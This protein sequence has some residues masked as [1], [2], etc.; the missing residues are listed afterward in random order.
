MLRRRRARGKLSLLICVLAAAVWSA[1]AQEVSFTPRHDGISSERKRPRRTPT[2]EINVARAPQLYSL[3][4]FNLLFQEMCRLLEAEGRRERI[5]LVAKD[6]AGDEHE[7]PSCRALARQI[8][9]SCAPKARAQKGVTPDVTS[10]MDGGGSSRQ[11]Q[12]E[13]ADDGGNERKRYPRT[14]LIDVLSRISGG[15]YEFSPGAGAVFDAL[16]SYELR[17]LASP[18]LTVGERD[19]YG[20]VLTYLFSAWDGRPGSPLGSATPSPEEVADLVQE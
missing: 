13:G 14:D 5:F 8:A 11:S 20:I 19:Y 9:Q 2:P 12:V 1:S 16:R 3:G 7:C 6:A 18:G 4:R 10:E 17:L 15:L